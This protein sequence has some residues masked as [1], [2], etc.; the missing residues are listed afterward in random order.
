VLPLAPDEKKDKFALFVR[1]LPVLVCC[2]GSLCLCQEATEPHALPL[3]PDAKRDKCARFW[4]SWLACWRW[5]QTTRSMCAHTQLSR[6]C[7]LL[8]SRC[9]MPALWVRD[10]IWPAPRHRAQHAGAAAAD[11]GHLRKACCGTSS[12]LSVRTCAVFWCHCCGVR[13]VRDG[14]VLRH[15]VGVQGER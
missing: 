3:A 11:S 9:P 10:R 6:R 1:A 7:R 2:S 4:F 5:R 14:Q 12:D 8:C 13:R 15:S